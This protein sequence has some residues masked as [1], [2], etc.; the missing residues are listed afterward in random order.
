MQHRFF[1]VMVVPCLAL[2]GERAMAIEI[3][4]LE[5]TI[6]VIKTD[7]EDRGDIS[8]RLELPEF[9]DQ[10]GPGEIREQRSAEREKA[11]D[12]DKS[13]RHSSDR[14]GIPENTAENEHKE[15]RHDSDKSK[16]H[17]DDAKEDSRERR[18][19]GKEDRHDIDEAREDSR[20]D[21]EDARDERE[22]SREGHEES[23][24]D[25]EESRD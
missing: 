13:D 8:H 22:E 7:R 1:M 5:V 9:S 18:A 21:Y 24:D 2:A 3:D 11:G 14:D 23:R 19:E 20:Q 16:D 6:R 17:R 25:R 4:D 12:K 10:R 15:D